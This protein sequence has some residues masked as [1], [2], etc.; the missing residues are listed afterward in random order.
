MANSSPGAPNFALAVAGALG[1]AVAGLAAPIGPFSFGWALPIA[2]VA[3]IALNG[4]LALG[5]DRILFGPLRERRSTVIVLVMASFG[6]ALTLRHLLEFIF[7]SKPVYFIKAPADRTA[8]RRRHLGRRR[9][10]FC[11]S[12]SPRSS[13]PRSICC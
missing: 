13:S 5:V 4:G 11:R 2:L 12:A 3:A 1:S 7:T 6:A 9:T 10:S 8:D